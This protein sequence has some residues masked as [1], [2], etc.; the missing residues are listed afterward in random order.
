[1]KI[2]KP[3]ALF[4]MA[5][6]ML[7]AGCQ[8]GDLIDNP[9]VASANSLV[10]VSLLL[11]HLTATVIRS[12]EMP[13]GDTYK[14]EQYFVSNYQYY[15]GLNTYNFANTTDSYDILK[16]ALK[17]QQQAVAQSSNRKYYAMA[18]F[19]KAYAYIWLTQ[20]VGDIPMTQAGDATNLTPKYDTEHDVFKNSLALLDTANNIMDSLNSVGNNAGQVLDASG[21]I[22]GLTNLQWQKAINTYKIR[23][24]I[25]L[26]KRAADNADLNIPQQ[27][28]A[29]VND[30]KHHPVMTGNTDNVVY[31]F[32]AASNSYPTGNSP[33]NNYGNI[34]KT[35]LDITTST[36]DPRTF[37]V[38]T[39][40]PAQITA[41]KNVSDFSA[42]V[43]ADINTPQAT[44]LTNS[45]NG[46]YS[47]T[48]YNRYYTS[49][50]GANAEPYI[51][52]G[53]PELCFNIAEGIY[54]G[55]AGGS[56]ATWYTNGIKASLAVYG[57]TDGQ[58][59]TVGDI[60][61]K[62][63]GTVTINI[64][65]FLNNVAYQG[66][67]NANS[68]NQILTQKYVALF[69]NS[70]WEAYYNWR[71]TG[72]PAFAYGGAGIGTPNNQIP[73][74]WMYPQSEITYNPDNYQ[75]AIQSQYGGSDDLFKDTWLTK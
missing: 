14:Y 29:I 21:D 22:F 46:A 71:R 24:L 59:Y 16:Y 13:W 63:L 60:A 8:K 26:S 17:L 30:S 12:S 35:Y 44:L 10:P 23:V 53:Y 72:V 34:C 65:Q 61:G 5:A 66:D 50:A 15:R 41:G 7:I 39:P 27:F 31:K 45:N 20:R 28:A 42:Y 52:I 36:Q 25:G 57:L 54:R 4:L 37:M 3:F 62:T 68:L 55:W 38:A 40:A 18:Q 48:N 56:A 67:G 47:F 19:F 43:G 64:S 6:T 70:G 51:F 75:S 33:Y 2:V 1:M 9:N 69:N 58:V 32:N 73:R 11:N 49:L 74:R